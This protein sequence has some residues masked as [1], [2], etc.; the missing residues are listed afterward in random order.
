MEIEERVSIVTQNRPEKLNAMNNQ[1]NAGLCAAVKRLKANHEIGC[2][3]LTGAGKRASST[4]VDIQEQ[5]KNDL[6][7]M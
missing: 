2:L 6:K 5:W 1:L 7:F 4:G 3:I